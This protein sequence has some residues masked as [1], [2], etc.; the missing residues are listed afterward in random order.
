MI[1]FFTHHVQ[2]KVSQQIF[3]AI[4][5]K[6]VNKFTPN[7]AHSVSDKTDKC[8]TNWHK[9]KN[10]FIPHM[11]AHYRVKFYIFDSQDCYKNNVTS[12]YS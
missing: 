11:F 9:N 2:R 4:T 6:T 3:I 5:L 7:L 1:G 12:R 8:L 10:Q